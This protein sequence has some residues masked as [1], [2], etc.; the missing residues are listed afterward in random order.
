VQLKAIT[1]QEENIS[2]INKLFKEDAE[3][4][5]YFEGDHTERGCPESL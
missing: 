2:A 5:L 4:L 3:Q 1:G